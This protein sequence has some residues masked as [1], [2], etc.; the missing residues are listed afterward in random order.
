M[1]EEIVS[2]KSLLVP[3][4]SVEVEYPG[5]EGFKL[6]LCFLSREELMKIRKKATKIEYK[7]RQ[8]VE[9]LNDDLFLQLYVDGCIQGWTGL[10]FSYL[11]SLAPVDVSAQKPDSTLAYSRENALFLMKASSNFDSFISETVTELSNF[12]VP[13]GSKS[14]SK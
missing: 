12:Q 1:S 9:T 10:K 7:N 14:A 11:E 5:F 13:S 6:S 4:K 2:L 8:P 3:T